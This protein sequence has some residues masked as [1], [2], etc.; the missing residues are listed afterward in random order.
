MKRTSLVLDEEILREATR[1][2]GAKTYSA[3]VNQAMQ[4]VLCIRKIQSLPEFFGKGLWQGDLT[5]MGEDKTARP[6][7]GH[8]DACA[9]DL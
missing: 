6:A 7:A 8:I 4:E 1:V 5:Q 3:A 9:C 2:L